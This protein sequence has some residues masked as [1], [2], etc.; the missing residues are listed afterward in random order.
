MEHRKNCV[1]VRARVWVCVC[2]AGGVIEPLRHD[3][4]LKWHGETREDAT[5]VNALKI[6]KLLD[7]ESNLQVKNEKE[8][9]ICS[10]AVTEQHNF[11]FADTL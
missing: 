5:N 6:G 11:S 7:E 1:C 3:M 10:M 9:T 2:G 4:Q 8:M